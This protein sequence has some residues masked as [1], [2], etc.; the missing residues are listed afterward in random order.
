MK[1]KDVWEIIE[2][3]ENVKVIGSKWVFSLKHDSE[4]KIQKYKARL[5]AQGFK[6][7]M[8]Y[9]LYVDDIIVIGSEEIKSVK[10][11]LA[12]KLEIKDLGIATNVLSKRKEGS[13]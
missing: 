12:S 3:P 13:C 7:Q 5:V 4:G 9:G 8:N 1:R 10:D 6:K 2:R 11:N